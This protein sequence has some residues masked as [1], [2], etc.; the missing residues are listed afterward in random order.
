MFRDEKSKESWELISWE[1]SL[2][3]NRSDSA[4]DGEEFSI[5]EDKIFG[6]KGVAYGF[7]VRGIGMHYEEPIFVI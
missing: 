3:L 1:L 4:M 2:S 6:Q 7:S 5:G